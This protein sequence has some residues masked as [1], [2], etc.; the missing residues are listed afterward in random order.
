MTFNV[1]VAADVAAKCCV[2]FVVAPAVPTPLQ[3]I[4]GAG[5]IMSMQHT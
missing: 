2:P 4:N 1:V 5:F 3:K